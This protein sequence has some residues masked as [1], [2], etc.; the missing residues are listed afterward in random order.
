MSDTPAEPREPSFAGRVPSVAARSMAVELLP[1]GAVRLG[2]LSSI[3]PRL[4]FVLDHAPSV[5][6]IHTTL[7]QVHGFSVESFE[8]LDTAARRCNEASPD[9]VVMEPRG[10]AKGD[11][12]EVLRGWGDLIAPAAP[13]VVWCT[14]LTPTQQLLDGGAQLGLR[15]VVIKPFRL[16][17]L[18]ALVVRVVRA[19]E[20]DTRLLAAG[21]DMW[22]IAGTL[23]ADVAHRW[24]QVETELSAAHPRPLSLVC[25]APV[26]DAVPVAVRSAIR[27]VDRVAELDGAFVVLLPDVDAAGAAV[28]A[29]R[30]GAAV[31]RLDGDARVW[32]ITRGDDE[33][34]DAL[35]DRAL[36]GG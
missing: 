17:P 8:D 13:P 21:V 24:L 7:L 23:P 31:A 6:T 14:T 33:A 9:V 29:R 18:M 22:T 12:L 20:R 35:L 3:G 11:A 16:E 26:S 34:A 10:F 15:G 28:V 36:H 4:A 19:H 32:A 1:E 25:V 5:R 27:S 2:T 30:V